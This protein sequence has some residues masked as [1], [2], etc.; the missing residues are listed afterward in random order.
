MPHTLQPAPTDSNRVIRSSI[1]INIEKKRGKLKY[2]P[3][4][5]ATKHIKWLTQNAIPPNKRN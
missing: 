1:Y 4:T 3:L 2:N 5:H